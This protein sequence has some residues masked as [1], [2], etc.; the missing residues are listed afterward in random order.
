MQVSELVVSAVGNPE[1][2]QRANLDPMS[3][4]L[5]VL[6]Y[7]PEHKYNSEKQTGYIWSRCQGEQE[8]TWL[9]VPPQPVMVNIQQTPNPVSDWMIAWSIKLKKA[10]PI[11]WSAISIS[12]ASPGSAVRGAKACPTHRRVRGCNTSL[13][14]KVALVLE[15]TLHNAK[16]SLTLNWTTLNKLKSSETGK[17]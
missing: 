4:F 14:L 10:K 6:N 13:I 17:K 15:H 2:F 11:T 8:V 7:S 12:R 5:S 9:I 16:W 3:Y 1:F